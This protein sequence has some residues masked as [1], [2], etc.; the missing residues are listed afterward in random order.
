MMKARHESEIVN[1][2]H[3]IDEE[4]TK[5]KLLRRQYRSIIVKKENI[6]C[7]LIGYRT[8]IDHKRMQTAIKNKSVKRVV[9]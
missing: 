7:A 5:Q 4:Y 2:V 1:L 9:S 6:I 8:D 3:D